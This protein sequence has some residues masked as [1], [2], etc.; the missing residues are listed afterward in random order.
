[1]ENYLPRMTM[2]KQCFLQQKKKHENIKETCTDGSKSI[3]K[4]AGFAAVIVDT[5]QKS[6][7]AWRSLYLHRWNNSNRNIIEGNPQKMVYINI[8]SELYAVYKEYKK[9]YH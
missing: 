5:I 1:M 8:L 2:R 7:S 4:K 6:D 9:E 3:G